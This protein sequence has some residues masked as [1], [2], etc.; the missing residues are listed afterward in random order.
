MRGKGC[1]AVRTLVIVNP[2]AGSGKAAARWPSIATLLTGATGR[3]EHVF[4]EEPNHATVLASRAARRGIERIIAVGGD[5][6]ANEVANG[7]LACRDTDAELPQLGVIPCGTGS[8]FCRSLGLKPDPA[9]AVARIASGATRMIDVG[10]AQYTCMSGAVAPRHFINVATFGLSGQISCN[11]NTRVKAS[12]LPG[13][14]RYL[15]GTLRALASYRPPRMRITIDGE[16][17][18]RGVYFAAVANA[19]YFGGGMHIAPT[20]LLDD[21]LFD[22]VILDAISKW[23]LARKIGRVYR[24]TH[25]NEPEITL[26]RGSHVVA[27]TVIGKDAAMG[28]LDLDGENPGMLRAEFRVLPRALRLSM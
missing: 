21:G 15:T 7:I 6:T 17:I 18:E 25:V 26:L 16:A 22:V 1:G 24:G 12:L 2:A 27:E 19:R 10:I 9:A 20:A 23:Q 4:T 14:V 28:L 13:P 8:D 3:F 11:L 5:G